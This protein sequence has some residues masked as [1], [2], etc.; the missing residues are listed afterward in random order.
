MADTHFK[1]NLER[2]LND[3][4][5]VLRQGATHRIFSDG[6]LTI[7]A[8]LRRDVTVG[9]IGSKPSFCKKDPGINLV[10]GGFRHSWKIV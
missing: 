3:V 8:R 4:G 10:S 9:G 2:P 1:G 6:P 7:G 5:N